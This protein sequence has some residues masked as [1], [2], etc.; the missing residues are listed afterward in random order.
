MTLDGGVLVAPPFSE[1]ALIML[2]TGWDYPTLA[3]TPVSIVEEMLVYHKVK[4]EILTQ[5][6]ENAG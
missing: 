2:A 3:A 6:A 4:S 5:R 1:D